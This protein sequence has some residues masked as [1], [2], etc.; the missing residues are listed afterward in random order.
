MDGQYVHR[1]ATDE[2]GH[3]Q[4]GRPAVQLHRSTQL[5]QVSLVKHGD[6]VAHGH[7]LHLV[8]GDVDGGGP[9]LSLEVNDPGASAPA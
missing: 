5:L 4:I 9:E 7:R 6:A 2:L 1:W 8:V 3:K